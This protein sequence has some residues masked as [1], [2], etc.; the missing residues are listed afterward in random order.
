VTVLNLGCG[1]DTTGDERLDVYRTKAT[2]LLANVEHPLP[3]KDESFD[4]VYSR[5]LFE[6]LRNPNVVLREMVRVARRG[7]EV[8][9]VTDNARYWRLVLGMDKAHEHYVG[10][11]ESDRHYAVFLPIHMKEHFEAVGLRSITCGFSGYNRRLK[12]V[13]RLLDA[14]GQKE[15]AWPRLVAVGVKPLSD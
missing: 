13:D 2:T 1:E 11:G 3:F 4:V 15:L 9:V 6:H 12:K 5:C 14:L 7:G 10:R 8:R